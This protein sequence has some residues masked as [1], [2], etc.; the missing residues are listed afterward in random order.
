[1]I[2]SS[3]SFFFIQFISRNNDIFLGVESER[4]RGPQQK[5]SLSFSFPFYSFSFSSS[6]TFFWE[7]HDFV[8][9][10]LYFYEMCFVKA[11]SKIDQCTDWWWPQI[12][13]NN[14]NGNKAWFYDE[15][16]RKLAQASNPASQPV[17]QQ[18]VCPPA[19]VPQTCRL[20]VSNAAGVRSTYT[21]TIYLCWPLKTT[22]IS[23]TTKQ[24][25]NQSI[26]SSYIFQKMLL[27]CSYLFHGILL[28]KIKAALAPSPYFLFFSF[29]SSSVLSL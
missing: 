19:I 15:R 28:N 24:S 22:S 27:C 26:P 2:N 8:A 29:L 18:P 5:A 11:K 20:C 12:S 1:M 13:N 10:C 9:A 16:K 23:A 6:T 3:S 25:I 14:K 17:S 21:F 4:V 7:S